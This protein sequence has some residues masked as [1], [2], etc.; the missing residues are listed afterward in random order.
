MFGVFKKGKLDY[1]IVGLGNPGPKYDN[2]RHNAGFMVI[3]AI[4][5]ELEVQVTKNKFHALIGDCEIAGHRCM[6]VKPLTFMNNSGESIRDISSFYKIS[7]SNIIIISD[8]ISLDVGRIRIR[9]NGSAG[10]HNGLKSIFELTGTTDYP[11]IKIGVGN[12]PNP[13]Y[14]LVKHVLGKFS[15][16][17]QQLI[18]SAVKN[19]CDA[20]KL[21]I[22]GDTDKAMNL[23]N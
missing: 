19:A 1:I 22:A 5:R 4:A 23:Y 6:L 12:K 11:R 16:E 13:D 2:T 9:R 10:G 21:M 20:V 8:D 14:D 17:D 18:G 3:D 15:K 7:A